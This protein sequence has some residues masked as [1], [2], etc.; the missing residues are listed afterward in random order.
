MQLMRVDGYEDYYIQSERLLFKGWKEDEF[1]SPCDRNE[2]ISS[3]VT[4]IPRI[5]KLEPD[6]FY[7]NNK[8]IDDEDSLYDIL[9]KSGILE[10]VRPLHSKEFQDLLRQKYQWWYVYSLSISLSF[11]LS[12]S[13]S[14]SVCMYVCRKL[15]L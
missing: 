7:K 10:G 4:N 1:F 3:I 8:N 15:F 14:L 2:I 5:I 6:L 11:L 12:L 13:I 9:F